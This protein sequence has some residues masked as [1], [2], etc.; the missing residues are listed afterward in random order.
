MPL[1]GNCG[2]DG[3]AETQLRRAVLY[4]G[5]CEQQLDAQQ[6]S[7]DTVCSKMLCFFQHTAAL[8]VAP[9]RPVPARV[10]AGFNRGALLGE[11]AAPTAAT[12]LRSAVAA[13]LA[14][15]APPPLARAAD[16][17]SAPLRPLADG[18][19]ACATGLALERLAIC[20]CW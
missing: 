12:G 6:C 9:P 20:N 4:A 7:K 19:A 14:G 5:A 11:A 2:L 1:L 3:P 10:M 17:F 16:P 8:A 18:A 13:L 15:A